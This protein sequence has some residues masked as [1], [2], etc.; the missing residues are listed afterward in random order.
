MLLLLVHGLHLEDT[1]LADCQSR[2]YGTHRFLLF[3]HN[4]WEG[5]IGS[6]GAETMD[7]AKHL[8]IPGQPPPTVVIRVI[9]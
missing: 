6:L 5:V 8:T 1:C 7:A 2:P 4:L 3:P 9:T